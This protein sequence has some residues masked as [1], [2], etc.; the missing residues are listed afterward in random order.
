MNI[1][2]QKLTINGTTVNAF[3]T[4]ATKKEARKSGFEPGRMD[5]FVATVDYNGANYTAYGFDFADAVDTVC[6]EIRYTL[7]TTN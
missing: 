3:G 6:K 5:A 7:N 4:K 2:V 1:L